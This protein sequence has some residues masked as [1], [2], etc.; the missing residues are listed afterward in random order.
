MRDGFADVSNRQRGA[1][2]CL[3]QPEHQRVVDDLAFLLHSIA[4]TVGAGGV[5]AAAGPAIKM[6]NAKCEHRMVRSNVV[7]R[8]M[9]PT[10]HGD[11]KDTESLIIYLRALPASAARADYQNVCLTLT[12]AH[13][14]GP[15]CATEST[16]SGPS[17]RTR[18]G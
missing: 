18:A 12:R 1:G 7:R 9:P 16:R 14:C 8:A 6:Q 10:S 2:P 4:T 15:R 5:W 17:D 11:T 13:T 3:Q